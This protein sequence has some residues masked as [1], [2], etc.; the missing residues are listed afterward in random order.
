VLVG[1]AGYYGKIAVVIIALIS[2]QDDDSEFAAA[3][4]LTLHNNGYWGRSGRMVRKL[5]NND[6]ER[7]W[8]KAAVT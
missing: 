4:W 7:M 3:D 1:A 5:M 8:K 6:L 2:Q